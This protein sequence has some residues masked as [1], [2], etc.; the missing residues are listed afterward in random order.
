MQERDYFNEKTEA[1]TQTLA[2]PSCKQAAE[3]Q[4]RWIVR[5]RKPSLP[6]RAN[7]D[8]RARFKAAKDYMVRADDAVRCSNARCG[9]RIEIT[10]MSVVLL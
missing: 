10:T 5:T 9:R 3:Y 6:G 7:E 4:V 8:D 2:C 1:R